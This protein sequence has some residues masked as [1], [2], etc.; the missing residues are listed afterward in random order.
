MSAC[1]FDLFIGTKA[2]RK[3]RKK[4]QEKGGATE[5]KRTGKRG[6]G[7]MHSRQYISV[8]LDVQIVDQVCSAGILGTVHFLW[9]RG[10]W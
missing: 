10:G 2:R 1:N 4:S 5:E 6:E 7:G 8:V 9:G 3:E